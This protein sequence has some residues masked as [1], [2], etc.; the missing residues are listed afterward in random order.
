MKSPVKYP[1][2]QY[3][4]IHPLLNITKKINKTKLEWKIKTN[5][6]RKEGMKERTKEGTKKGRKKVRKRKMDLD[7][8][9]VRL[10]EWNTNKNI[11]QDWNKVN[12]NDNWTQDIVSNR[13]IKIDN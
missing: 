9:C 8:D 13:G 11:F 4:C 3:L 6:E 2:S 10:N 12:N 7:W 5:E 1:V